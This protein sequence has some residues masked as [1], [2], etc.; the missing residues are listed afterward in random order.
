VQFGFRNVGGWSKRG[1]RPCAPG[2]WGRNWHVGAN[3]GGCGSWKSRGPCVGGTPGVTAFDEFENETPDGVSNLGK[4]EGVLDPI[5]H[6]FWRG[7]L[8]IGTGDSLQFQSQIRRTM[9]P[10]GACSARMLSIKGK[11]PRPVSVVTQGDDLLGVGAQQLILGVRLEENSQSA[12]QGS[13]PE[14]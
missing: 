2:I 3:F 9:G 8:D 11:R 4:L 10:S 13:L 7:S 12:A 14:S 1:P 6:D 5:N